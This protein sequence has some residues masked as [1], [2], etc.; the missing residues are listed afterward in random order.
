MNIILGRP[1]LGCQV[2]VKRFLQ[3][4]EDLETFLA[5]LAMFGD[6]HKILTAHDESLWLLLVIYS[7]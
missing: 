5:M 3:V 6:Y 7:F 4:L 2:F 1:L